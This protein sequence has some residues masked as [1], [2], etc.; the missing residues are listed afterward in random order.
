MS[1]PSPFRSYWQL[2]PAVDFLNHGSFGATPTA[3]LGAQRE[4]QDRLE[5]EPLRFLSPERDL[6]SKLD[7]VRGVIAGLVASDPADVAF[8][9]NATDGVNAVLRSLSLAAGDE[10][11]I[12]NHG[13]NACNNAARFV[14]ER[15][16]AKV[17]VAQ[18]PFPI[19]GPDDVLA[20]IEAEFTARTRLLLVDH[21]TSS[22]GLVLPIGRIISAA[23]QRGIRVLVDGAHAPGMVPVDVQ[24]IGA[25]YYTGNHHKWLC[26]PKSSGFLYVRRALQREVRPTV[27]SHA[28]N[29]ARPKRSRFLAEFDWTGTFDPTALLATPA[30]V[31]F[32]ESLRPGG[33]EEHMQANRRLALEAR[34][35][36]IHT[37]R[38][39]PPAPP[40]MIGSMVT[41]PLPHAAEPATGDMATGDI[42]PLQ[43]RL[44]DHYRIEVPVFPGSDP[45]TRYLRISAQAYNDLNQY[46]RLA[47]ALSAEHRFHRS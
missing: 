24:Q 25:D 3:V 45:G 20:A 43:Q 41:I 33:L 26:G 7:A 38:S 47:E 23:H 11:V 2:D 12:S 4:L 28:A 15:A 10:I 17:R 40:E 22:T 44:F 34:Q 6:E 35:V 9:R 16:E 19:A 8:V 27:I 37:L 5:R 31:S 1:K 13:Y 30:A 42:D 29:R 46:Q 36:L 18:I 32:L 39:M 14:A 21:V